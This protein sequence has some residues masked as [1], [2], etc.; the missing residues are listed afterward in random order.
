MIVNIIAPTYQRF[1]TEELMFPNSFQ[2]YSSHPFLLK[3]QKYLLSM[4]YWVHINENPLPSLHM[5]L[6]IWHKQSLCYK[7][8]PFIPDATR[9][10]KARVLWM[11]RGLLPL[12]AGAQ[13]RQC[14]R[15]LFFLMTPPDTAWLHSP[16]HFPWEACQQCT[17]IIF[18]FLVV[19][20]NNS[21]FLQ[22]ENSTRLIFVSW[23]VNAIGQSKHPSEN[24]SFKFML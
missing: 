5:N 4:S 13:C 8:F 20:R 9:K 10:S 16:D 17:L 2:F 19:K 18:F 21:S 22:P 15:W 1:V 11:N 3:V 6:T 14:L 7:Q 12:L 24:L 23:K